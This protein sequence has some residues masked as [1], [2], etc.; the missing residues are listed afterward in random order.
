VPHVAGPVK[1][2]WLFQ[3]DIRVF[4]ADE[5]LVQGVRGLGETG[6]SQMIGRVDCMLTLLSTAGITRWLG[7]QID[8]H[9]IDLADATVGDALTFEQE[10]GIAFLSRNAPVDEA[11]A[12]FLSF[13]TRHQ[14][15]LRAVV[16][17]EHGRPTEAPLG[18]ITASD[19]VALED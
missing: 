8:G 4:M 11:R 18:I 10:G 2:L 14:Q 17:T 5:P 3:R 6:H 9:A 19:L 16:I 12:L 7:S 1:V 15:R 13:P